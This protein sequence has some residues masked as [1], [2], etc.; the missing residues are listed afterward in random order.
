[1]SLYFKIDFKCFILY[2][3][4]EVT[5]MDIYAKLKELLSKQVKKINLDAITPETKLEDLGLDSLDTAELLINIEQ[6]FNLSEVSQEEMLE[7]KTIEDVK[8]LIEK[9]RNN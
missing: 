8:N 7:V 9:K 6:E 3:V 2:N 4:K 1:M 5:H